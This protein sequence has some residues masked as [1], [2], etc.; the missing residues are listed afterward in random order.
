ML[1]RGISTNIGHYNQPSESYG[2]VKVSASRKKINDL[3]SLAKSNE[4]NF[5][6]KKRAVSS[7]KIKNYHA[8]EEY[9]INMSPNRSTRVT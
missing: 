9:R 8:N 6:K 3:G 2:F 1:Q 7:Y 4:F 5:E